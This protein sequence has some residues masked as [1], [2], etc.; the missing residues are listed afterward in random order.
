MCLIAAARVRCRNKGIHF[1]LDG[2]AEELQRRIDTGRCELSGAAFD[3]SPGRKA[4]SPSLDRR[5]PDKGY[6][7]EN[8][9][10]ICHALNAALGDWGEAGLA[11]ILAAWMQRC[12]AINAKAAQA[13]IECVMA[14]QP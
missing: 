13:F 3:M 10:V 5:N 4:T 9:R 1:E 8:V 6:T 14:C 11:P 7:P 2:F 12:N